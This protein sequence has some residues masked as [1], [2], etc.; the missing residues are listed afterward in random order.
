MPTDQSRPTE[1]EA[2]ARDDESL[3]AIDRGL[4]RD[5]T[6]RGLRWVSGGRVIAEVLALGTSVILARLI[7]PAEFG[8]VAVA[9]TVS[10]IASVL[11]NAGI[12]QALVQRKSISRRHVEAAAA[13]CTASGLTLS[14]ALFVAAPAAAGL[15]G[16]RAEEGI[17][18]VSPALLIMSLGATPTAILQRRLDFRSITTAE[19]MASLVGAVA[20]VAL[21][22]AGWGAEAII[23]GTLARAAIQSALAWCFARPPLPRWHRREVRE[24]A[25]FGIPT[26]LSGLGYQGARNVDYVIV[27]AQLGLTQLGLYWRAYQMAFEYQSKIT[28]IMQKVALPVLS[29]TRD[30][31]DIR[32]LRYRIVRVHGVIIFPLLFLFIAVAPELIP[33]LFGAQWRGTVEPAQILTV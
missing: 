20:S 28:V 6:L 22:L 11:S 9:L 13:L 33:W 8:V 5:A 15:L 12:A 21:A 27:G 30:L 7:S 17:R 18:V 4:L 29:R 23:A 31:D 14:V 2:P 25:G 10:V 19:V 1:Q 3:A 24:L 26:A 16:D 32:A